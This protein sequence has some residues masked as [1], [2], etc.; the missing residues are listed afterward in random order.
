MKRLLLISQW[1]SGH[2]GSLDLVGIPAG[3]ALLLGHIISNA[4][5]FLLIKNG[6]LPNSTPAG[7]LDQ[8][9]QLGL[10]LVCRFLFPF[11]REVGNIQIIYIDIHIGIGIN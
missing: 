8:L 2:L 11:V 3:T 5:M 6:F 1:A 10:F 9:I 7:R 4:H